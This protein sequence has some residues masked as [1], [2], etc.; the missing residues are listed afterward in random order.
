MASKS[1]YECDFCGRGQPA[2]I[3]VNWTGSTIC[4]DCVELLV[5]VVAQ[6]SPE[7]RE[8]IVRILA[9]SGDDAPEASAD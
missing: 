9:E 2:D 7:A 4:H 5:R 8:R 1:N 6:T 3:I